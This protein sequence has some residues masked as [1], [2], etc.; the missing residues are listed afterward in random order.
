MRK[1]RLFCFFI[2]LLVLP[3][4]GCTQAQGQTSVSLSRTVLLITTPAG[5]IPSSSS[6]SAAS[7]SKFV[8][9][10][11][12]VVEGGSLPRDYT[13]DGNSDTLPLE[14]SGAPANTK[15]YA[16]VMYT[17]PSANETH[18]YWVLY[19]IPPSVHSLVKNETEVGTLGNN[20]VNERTEY[21]P[22]CSKGSGP[23]LYT[24]TIYSLSAPPQFNVP[25]AKVSRDVLLAAIKDITLDKAELNVIYSR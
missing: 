2:V 8:L 25:P 24:Y 15:S 19:N 22:P 7:D 9:R 10:S 17:I 5:G 23:K 11:P 21:A 16:I 18:W 12:E 6:P 4:S 13:C 14:W 3:V 1:I 20:S